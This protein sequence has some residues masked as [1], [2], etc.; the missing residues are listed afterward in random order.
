M[1][2]TMFQL[3]QI[4]NYLF[5]I[6]VDNTVAICSCVLMYRVVTCSGDIR[7]FELMSIIWEFEFF[8]IERYVCSCFQ[9]HRIGRTPSLF[10]LL[11]FRKA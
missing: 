4:I 3:I 7:K 10:H 9:I 2:I 11:I 1:K 6:P 8:N 5:M